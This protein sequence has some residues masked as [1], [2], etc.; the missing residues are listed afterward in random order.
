MPSV[1]DNGT[2]PEGSPFPEVEHTY[3]EPD[4]APNLAASMADRLD[5]LEGEI[6]RREAAASK[7][8]TER[9]ERLDDLGVPSDKRAY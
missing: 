3:M 8:L 5:G 1:E 9:T 7:H 4:E 2:P 6:A